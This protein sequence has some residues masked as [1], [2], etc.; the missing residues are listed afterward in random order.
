MPAPKAVAEGVLARMTKPMA[1]QQ[2]MLASMPRPWRRRNWPAL[3]RFR[4]RP[5]PKALRLVAEPPRRGSHRRE[6]LSNAQ[7]A[8]GWLDVDPQSRSLAAS[9]LCADLLSRGDGKHQARQVQ[10]LQPATNPLSGIRAV[11][12]I[13]RCRADF[14]TQP[15]RALPLQEGGNLPTI[16]R[17]VRRTRSG[18]ADAA[19]ALA[20]ISLLQRWHR[21]RPGQ[22]QQAGH[23]ACRLNASKQF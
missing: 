23:G 12:C 14:W 3:D 4:A 18:Q 9:P 5:A 6:E 20:A 1:K 21:T 2:E 16:R 19:K 17:D 11:E 7:S 10:Q 13:R 8:A 15:D 22:R